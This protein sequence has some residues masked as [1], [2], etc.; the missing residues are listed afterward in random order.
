MTTTKNLF[1]FLTRLKVKFFKDYHNTKKYEFLQLYSCFCVD[2]VFYL[3]F[4]LKLFA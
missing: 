3:S 2:F 1:D 4:F